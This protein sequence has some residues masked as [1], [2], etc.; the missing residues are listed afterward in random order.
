MTCYYYFDDP[1]SDLGST[2]VP[3]DDYIEAILKIA[4]KS[5]VKISQGM[6]F[7]EVKKEWKDKK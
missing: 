5:G 2:P 3:E 1:D 4:E 6:I 7:E